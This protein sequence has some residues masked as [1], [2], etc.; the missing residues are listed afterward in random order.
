M[1]L[2]EVILKNS[3]I[4]TTAFICAVSLVVNIVS[5][6][7]LLDQANNRDNTENEKKLNPKV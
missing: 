1:L 2:A 3:I 5:T 7:E 4:Y 6:K